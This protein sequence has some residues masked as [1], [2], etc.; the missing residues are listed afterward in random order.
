M[1]LNPLKYH[2][3]FAMWR[4]FVNWTQNLRL[5]HICLSCVACNLVY[6]TWTYIHEYY[7][8]RQHSGIIYVM[9]ESHTFNIF[10]SSI[11][12]SETNVLIHI[13]YEPSLL[14]PCQRGC[15]EGQMWHFRIAFSS[16]VISNVNSARQEFHSSLRW[17]RTGLPMSKLPFC[18]L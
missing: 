1:I 11:F 15:L 12:R 5:L 8:L 17:M 13:I 4:H 14:L 6:W 3:I 7:E 10:L 2:E 16:L 18:G 9:P